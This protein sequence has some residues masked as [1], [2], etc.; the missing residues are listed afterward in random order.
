[1]YIWEKED[2]TTKIKDIKN[3]L[4]DINLF[5]IS[6]KTNNKIAISKKSIINYMYIFI[7]YEDDYYEQHDIKYL[8]AFMA[9][10]VKRVS[11]G[12]NILPK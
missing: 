2:N 11:L 8:Y 10:Y 7:I 5:S 12:E 4:F 3:N 1:M 6:P 9:K